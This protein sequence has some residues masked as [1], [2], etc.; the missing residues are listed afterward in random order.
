VDGLELEIGGYASVGGHLGQV[1]SLELA[2][3]GSFALGE[4]VMLEEG[5]GPF[6]ALPVDCAATPEVERWLTAVWPARVALDVGELVVEPSVRFL[7]DAGRFDR[8]TFFWGQS[9]SG[10]TYSLGTVLEQ[11]SAANQASNRRSRSELRLRPPER[12]PRGAGR[13]D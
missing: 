3:G 1:Q 6:G 13:G 5:V 4:G 11:L 12:A 9:G 8:H 7:L 10:K 2:R